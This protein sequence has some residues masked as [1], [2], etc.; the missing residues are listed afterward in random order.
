MCGFINFYKLVWLFCC[1]LFLWPTPEISRA[2]ISAYTFCGQSSIIS[3]FTHLAPKTD[4]CVWSL[5]YLT[6]HIIQTLTYLESHIWTLFRPTLYH[7][8]DTKLNAENMLLFI[9]VAGELG[10]SSFDSVTYAIAFNE[11]SR[12]MMSN[13]SINLAALNYTQLNE[14]IV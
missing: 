7:L 8:Q 11:R 1:E 6:V 5:N 2:R 13:H 10:F 4:S 9:A 12:E 14:T 3:F